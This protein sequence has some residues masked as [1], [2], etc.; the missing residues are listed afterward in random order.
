MAHPPVIA[1]VDTGCEWN[2]RSDYVTV[3]QIR[4]NELYHRLSVSQLSS[5][6]KSTLPEGKEI[7]HTA[8]DSRIHG[9]GV[10]FVE[11]SDDLYDFYNNIALAVESDSI[12]LFLNE[13]ASAD[14]TAPRP[15]ATDFDF[16]DPDQ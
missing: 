5:L 9:H 3:T 2:L 14:P 4:N 6:S 7:T 12:P 10:I 11:A 16:G 8:F 13:L 1:K 15:F